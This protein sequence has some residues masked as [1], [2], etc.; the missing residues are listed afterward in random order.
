M[1]AP[2]CRHSDALHAFLSS[3]E[4]DPGSVHA[5]VLSVFGFLLSRQMLGKLTVK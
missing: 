3:R 4:P 1:R 5:W 2:A